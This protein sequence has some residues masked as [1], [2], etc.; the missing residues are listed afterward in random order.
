LNHQET[1]LIRK[2]CKLRTPDGS[3]RFVKIVQSFF[4]GLEQEE[5]NKMLTEMRNYIFAVK[6]GNIQ[7]GPIEYA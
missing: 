3:K 7:P 2:W 1:Q 6:C 4:N 5:R